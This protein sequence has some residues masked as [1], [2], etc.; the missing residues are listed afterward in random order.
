[1]QRLQEQ[2]RK[3]QAGAV[4]EGQRR[5]QVES[6]EHKVANLEGELQ[7][8]QRQC[9]QVNK[10]THIYTLYVQIRYVLPVA[11]S[12]SPSLRLSRRETPY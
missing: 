1:M 2:V 6:L 12:Q 9:E 7:A 8:T 11:D 10:Y 5:A 3:L 4:D